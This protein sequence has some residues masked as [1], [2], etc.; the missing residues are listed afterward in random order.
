[1]AVIRIN[2]LLI[3]KQYFIDDVYK[4][5]ISD[6]SDNIILKKYKINVRLR[7]LIQFFYIYNYFIF[8]FVFRRYFLYN[9]NEIIKKY[10]IFYLD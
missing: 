6:N 3:E 2:I 9:E 10:I 8:S 1:M 7:N 4:R 5:T